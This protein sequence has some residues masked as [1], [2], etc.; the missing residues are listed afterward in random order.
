LLIFLFRESARSSE[1]NECPL[2][3]LNFGNSNSSN[4]YQDEPPLVI[5]DTKV[6]DLS[7]GETLDLSRNN[8]QT[9]DTKSNSSD[10]Q[11]S[12]Q[13][14]NVFNATN[15]P[16]LPMHINSNGANRQGS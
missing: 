1:S 15:L 13:I 8:R 10:E 11:N 9:C 12:S 14:N 6:D 7:F 4:P 5:E 16:V 2:K 3:S